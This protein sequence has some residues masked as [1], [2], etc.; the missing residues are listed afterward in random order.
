MLELQADLWEVPADVRVITINQFVRNDGELVMGRGCAAEAARRYPKLAREMGQVISISLK[1]GQDFAPVWHRCEYDLITFVVKPA[2]HN[3]MP[4]QKSHPGWRCGYHTQ[5]VWCR[6]EV[7]RRVLEGLPL[8]VTMVDM[9]KEWRR[10]VLPRLGCGYGGLV[11]EH[12]RPI[13]A[14]VLDDRFTVVHLPAKVPH[15]TMRSEPNPS[16]GIPRPRGD[17]P[18]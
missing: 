3:V 6:V 7:M 17:I 16:R 9:R 10:V 18:T 8:L 15:P 4:E 11:W 14:A 5:S 13:L 12:V 2:V 1:Q